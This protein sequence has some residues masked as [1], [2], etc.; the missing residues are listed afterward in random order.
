MLVPDLSI[1]NTIKRVTTHHSIFFRSHASLK[2]LTV[3]MA[4]WYCDPKTWKKQ[5]VGKPLMDPKKQAMVVAIL[6]HHPLRRYHKHCVPLTL[7]PAE[8][9]TYRACRLWEHACAALAARGI[10][11]LTIHLIGDND[12]LV[13]PSVTVRIH[14]ARPGNEQPPTALII[15]KL[16]PASHL[17]CDLFSFPSSTE[18]HKSTT[19]FFTHAALVLRKSSLQSSIKL[20]LPNSHYGVVC[21]T[22]RCPDSVATGN[23]R[24]P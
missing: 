6:R 24:A 19:G 3:D 20:P 5:N 7:S 18:L 8:L 1:G 22:F 23:K 15:R 17:T 10:I 13:F 11:Y 16:L 12:S 14:S 9:M 21:G 4:P 2:L